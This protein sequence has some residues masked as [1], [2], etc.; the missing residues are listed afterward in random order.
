MDFFEQQGQ[1]IVL[2]RILA[3]GE[4]SNGLFLRNRRILRF[5][6]AQSVDFLWLTGIWVTKSEMT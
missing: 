1:I 5:G 6:F 2:D 4:Y 3:T